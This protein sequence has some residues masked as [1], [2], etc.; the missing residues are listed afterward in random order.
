M[1]Q[2]RDLRKVGGRRLHVGQ[3]H[4]I[5]AFGAHLAHSG[6]EHRLGFGEELFDGFGQ[7]EDR[8]RWPRREPKVLKSTGSKTGITPCSRRDM[9]MTSWISFSNRSV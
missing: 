8:Q 5:L 6:D 4:L 2:R 7:L 3:H 9:V 1:L